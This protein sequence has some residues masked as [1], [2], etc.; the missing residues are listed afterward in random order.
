MKY[1]T[2]CNEKFD[3]SLSFC[4]TDG[5]VLEEDSSALI[6][7]VLDGQY[8]IES[9]L[10][11][12][13]MGAVYR[14]RHIL[15][16]DRVA[17]KLLPPEMRSNT[18][19][20]RRFQREGQAARRFRHPNA[21]TVYDLRTSADGTI[22]L[23]MEYVEGN[24][25]DAELRKRRK[26]TP[27]EAVAVLDPIM[28]VLNAAHAMG[29][30][31]RDLKPENIMI[32]KPST[33]GEPVVK[34][35]DLGIAKLREVAGAEKAG[36]TAL[37]MAGQMLGTPYYMSPEQWG[38]LP[39]DGNSEIDGRADIYSLGVVF[40]ELIAG[41]RP[42]S[43]VTLLE[44]R[45]QHVSITPPTLHEVDA[46]VPESFSQAIARAIAKDRS[47][48]QA[49]A[50]ELEKELRAALAAAGIAPST[51]LASAGGAVAGSNS[52]AARGPL[53]A[54]ERTAATMV[55]EATPT[56]GDSAAPQKLVPSGD[57]ASQASTMP[58]VI[59]AQK[60]DVEPD[61]AGEGRPAPTMASL[62]GGEFPQPVGTTAAP[63]RRSP[64]PLV[65]VGIIV[66]VLVVGA[67]GYAVIH[68]MGASANSNSSPANS[69]KAT[70]PSGTELAAGAHE[71]GRYW[72]EVN[73]ANKIDAIRAGES[74]P[75]DSGQQFKFHFS[76]SENGYLYIIGPGDKN[77]PTTF[78][79]SKP[80]TAFG[81]KTNEVKSGQDFA[82]PSETNKTTNWL[83]LDK[84]AG[85]DEF[86]L[87]FSTKALDNLGFLNSPALHELTQDEQK[88]LDVVRQ[89]AKANSV[90]AEVVKTGA[91]PFV[92]V[93]VPQNAEGTPVIFMVRLEHK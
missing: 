69:S 45:R 19:W 10:G 57:L 35:L 33:G 49:T 78:L 86:T 5:E 29:V 80:A 26:F 15:L 93:K 54:A 67:G 34:L 4:P 82:F 3:D 81:V 40:Y 85:T 70:G 92:S 20:L 22:Y 8:Q 68:F 89:Q 64:L 2:S 91:S 65:A 36:N 52:D 23:V 76:P 14:A 50:G 44:L 27:A 32:G 13:G 17:I 90:G 73:A 41:R 38:E 75:M 9:M 46:S 28:G 72:V 59:A 66:L 7:N 87:I 42:F 74:L 47:H 21:V 56:S 53:T 62:P 18:E 83:N 88:E 61:F 37:T 79:T 39:D 43:G 51:S 11:K 12:G 71:I 84:S 31:H 63:Q 48:R 77:A 16:G 30:V 58:T 25:L 6:G 60:Q 55:G 1:C 24:T